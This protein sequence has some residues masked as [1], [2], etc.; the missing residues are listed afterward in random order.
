MKDRVPTY[1]GRITLTPVEGQTNTYDLERADSPTETGTALSKAN[2]LTDATAA[3]YG[4]AAEDDAT[5]EDVFD[6]LAAILPQIGDTITTVR[7]DLDTNW[8]LCNGSLV[9]VDTYSSLASLL[10]VSPSGTWPTKAFSTSITAK[11][12]A[13]GDGYF[14]AVG[15]AGKLYYT[16]NPSEAWTE[17]TII[18]SSYDLKA[19]AYGNGYWV[20]VGQ[21]TGGSYGRVFYTTDITSSWTEK[22][23]IAIETAAYRAVTYAN[24]YWVAVGD[25]GY[26]Y[27]IN[28]N[29]TGTWTGNRRETYNYYGIAYGDGNWVIAGQG[30]NTYYTTDL[31]AGTWT[32]KTQGSDILYGLTYVN[33]YW[34]ATGSGV[35]RYGTSPAD[36]W[37]SNPPAESVLFQSPCI[38]W[39]LLYYG[40]C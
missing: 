8:L 27:Y 15:D 32:N 7:A 19:I 18:S 25:S 35:L 23:A 12:I 33:G 40:W 37:T 26:L 21:Q 28:G 30:G 1:P 4:Y 10:S 6:D 14:A 17:T 9:D 20:A 36:T 38:C 16:T 2:L 39:R 29:P 31:S 3:K 22:G 13:Y 11:K 24:E 5:P 34:V